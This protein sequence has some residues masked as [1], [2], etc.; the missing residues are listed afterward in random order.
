M[1]QCSDDP[2]GTERR[3]SRHAVSL[4]IA[5]SSLAIK[6]AAKLTTSL[7]PS[8]LASDFKL[9]VL[10]LQPRG[11]LYKAVIVVQLHPWFVTAVDR[12]YDINCFF[13]ETDAMITSNL[14]VS[15]LRPNPIQVG[16]T[17][18][19]CF[20]SLHLDSPTGAAVR[21]AKVGDQVWHVW[22][23]ESDTMGMLVHNCVV[24]DGHGTEIPI[25]D[26]NG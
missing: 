11:L 3:T 4:T 10:Q 23:C 20:Y 12:A 24:H 9:S 14:E 15:S 17:L 22:E 13:S 6:R 2:R 1:E 19:T 18:P 7:R 5:R 8:T 21:Y 16:P 25:I 26:A